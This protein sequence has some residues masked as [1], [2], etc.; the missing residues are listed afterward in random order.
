MEEAKKSCEAEGCSA[1]AVGFYFKHDTQVSI[2]SL[3]RPALTKI[4]PMDLINLLHS[5][6]D[7]TL[8]KERKQEVATGQA[9]LTSLQKQTQVQLEDC[10]QA[11]ASHQT[12]TERTVHLAYEA[13]RRKVKQHFYQVDVMVRSVLSK[14]EHYL[15]VK[16]YIL[17]EIAR[18]A[19]REGNP[20]VLTQFRVRDIRL[21]LH[22]AISR[23]MHLRAPLHSSVQSEGGVGD[24][25]AALEAYWQCC[26]DLEVRSGGEEVKR[27]LEGKVARL[28]AERESAL[29]SLQTANTPYVSRLLSHCQASIAQHQAQGEHWQVLDLY[30]AA[31]EAAG[32]EAVSK[33]VGELYWK[34]AEWYKKYAPWPVVSKPE[35]LLKQAIRILQPHF[36]TNL[37]TVSVYS[38]L[39]RLYMEQNHLLEACH[40]YSL[41]VGVLCTYWPQEKDT[42]EMMVRYG[43]VLELAQKPEEAAEAWKEAISLSISA[44]SDTEASDV[45]FSEGKYLLEQHQT[46]MAGKL[47]SMACALAQLN[48]EKLQSIS[49]V[50]R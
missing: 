31:L 45:Y 41:A 24:Y 43:S 10:L 39:G 49:T 38:S 3:H 4:H 28:V 27:E 22:T 16:E 1:A 7:E 30:E 2:C 21:E 50:L 35:K 48:W 9:Y 6:H 15:R 18:N 5:P 13:E 32:P 34:Y 8:L 12:E 23:S 14:F 26:E 40:T 33:E 44:L 25:G 17:P 29:L 46:G 19:I 42:V 37:P 36:P 47:L 11:L 20:P